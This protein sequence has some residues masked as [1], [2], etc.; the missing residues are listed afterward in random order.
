MHIKI[1]NYNGI[2]ALDYELAE[3]KINFLF[4]ISGAGKS[5]IASALN[6]CELDSH[7]TVG[8]T[9]N[10][11]CVEVDGKNV[12][13]NEFK[14][15]NLDYMNNVLIN[16]QNGADIYTILFGDGGQIANCKANY[17]T[18]IS[19]LIAVKNDLVNAIRSISTLVKELKL[20]INSKNKQFKATSLNVVMEKN[21]AKL[22]S[23]RNAITYNST[24][25]K[26][27]KDGTGMASYA[28]GI[29]PFCTRKM[30]KNRID[31]IDK[32]V[33]FDSK[34]YEKINAQNRI[35]TELGLNAPDW[36]KKREINEFNKK[37]F[38]YCSIKPELEKF[39]S[40]IDLAST[41]EIQNI[42]IEVEKPSKQ[43]S[44]LYPGI[45]TAVMTFNHKISSVKRALGKLNAETQKVINKNSKIINEKMDLLG[46]PYKFIKKNIDE[47]LKN[48]EY[49]ICHILDTDKDIDR[50]HNLSFG[51]KNLIGLL[52]FLLANVDC[53]GLIIDDPASSFDDYRRK[54]IFDMIYDFHK[55]NTVLVLSHDPVFVKYALF[56]RFDS[57]E[58]IKQKRSISELKQKFLNDTGNINFME[59]YDNSIIKDIKLDDFGN[60]MDFVLERLRSLPKEIN[61]QTAINLRIYFELR[62]KKYPLVYSYLS[63]IIHKT[64]YEIIQTEID[65]KSSKEKDLVNIINAETGLS[66]DLL[67][68]DYLS[69]IN[70]Y[71]Y[72]DFEK[73]VKCRELLNSRSKK[74]KV[75]KDELS[76]IIHMNS[77]YTICLN[78]YKFNYFSKYVKEY[79]D[80]N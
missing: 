67:A 10:D 26:W 18:A 32:L 30:T 73:I 7:V 43:L 72:L 23:Y 42:N 62:K 66:Y 14:I 34:S 6:D 3:N 21:A 22:P 5:S 39:N 80:N 64:D 61:Y 40:Y 33:V 70:D 56:H 16:K 41:M 25:I 69:K 52:L 79:I 20:G 1:E 24:Q 55:N 63:A 17:Q 9:V 50:V 57:D 45:A 44:E 13:Y 8:K 59:S 27:M 58:K 12:N 15:F 71:N 53:P 76:N 35:F 28:N 49:N 36:R 37:L 65:K 19:D 31:K 77:A 68:I 29:C 75:I 46:I 51:E 38:K 54:I 60:L 74:D 4:G 47:E 11:L 48:A 2:K 78:P